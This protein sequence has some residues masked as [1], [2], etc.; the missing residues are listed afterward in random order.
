MASRGRRHLERSL[1]R[2]SDVVYEMNNFQN[3]QVVHSSVRCLDVWAD[4]SSRAAEQSSSIGESSIVDSA[5]FTH[6]K[7]RTWTNCFHC[8]A[9][10]Q[11]TTACLRR[12]VGL[13]RPW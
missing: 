12:H 11:A 4:L 7:C 1:G 3:P 10:G 6:A 8:N 13:G 5:F 9:S 2:K